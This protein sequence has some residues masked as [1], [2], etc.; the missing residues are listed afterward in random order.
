MAR[1]CALAASC[2]PRGVAV[3]KASVRQQ[4]AEHYRAERLAIML[5]APD[6]T[7][8]EA[9]WIADCEEAAALAYALDEAPTCT[10]GAHDWSGK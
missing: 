7:E 5:E 10:C 6:V 2:A 4:V 1:S 9:R 3:G 8:T